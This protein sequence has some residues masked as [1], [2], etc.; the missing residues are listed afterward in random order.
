MKVL[1][2][3][4]N[5]YWALMNLELNEVSLVELNE[6]SRDYIQA[7]EKE[8]H[9]LSCN[10]S[11]HQITHWPRIKDLPEDEQLPFRKWLVGQTCPY[12]VGVSYDEQ[13]GYYQWDYDDWKQSLSGKKGFWD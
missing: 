11:R 4:R 12:I 8:V 7:L 2:D 6:V 3:A 5:A 13:D 10:L 1:E 9:S